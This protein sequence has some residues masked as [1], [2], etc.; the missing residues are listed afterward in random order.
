MTSVCPQ[1]GYDTI[2]DCDANEEDVRCRKCGYGE[3]WERKE[4]S[5]GAIKYELNVDKGRWR[6]VLLVERRNRP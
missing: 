6:V 4:S 5:D 2:F 3:D 1:C